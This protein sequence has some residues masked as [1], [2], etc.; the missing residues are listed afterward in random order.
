MTRQA[1][2]TAALHVLDEAGLDG[3]S[4]RRVADE[5]GTG[6]ASL[7][8]HVADKERLI[9][10]MLDRVMGEIELPE[11]DPTRWEEQVREFARAGREMFRR[12]R[13]IGLAS[14][15]RVPMG[16]NLIRIMEWLLA[17]LR[18]A[19][20]P[21]RPATW[22]ADLLALIAAAQSIEDDLATT[23]DDEAIA[24]MGEYL[25]A[26]PADRFPNLAAVTFEMVAGGAD[27]RFEFGLELL[28]R[29]L[30]SFVEK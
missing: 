29:G 21:D 18:G 11:P 4:M 2:V 13:D 27:D 9:H 7:Y 6:A 17:V 23:G 19:G 28:L 1:I 30:A 14:L 16:P 15:G 10:L 22:F 5:L 24:H 20:I 26:L 25:A 3:L 12:H 8:W